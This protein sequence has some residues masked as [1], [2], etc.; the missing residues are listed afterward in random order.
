MRVRINL[1]NGAVLNGRI[2]GLEVDSLGEDALP[3]I[4]NDDRKFIPFIQ[5]SGREVQ[6]LKNAIAWIANDGD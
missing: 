3:W 5:P 1:I 6:L 4:L 2:I